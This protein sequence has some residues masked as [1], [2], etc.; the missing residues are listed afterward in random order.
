MTHKCNKCFYEWDGRTKDPKQ[1][2]RCKRYDWNSIKDLENL[3]KGDK[4]NGE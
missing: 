1:C 2:P 4:K 3:R